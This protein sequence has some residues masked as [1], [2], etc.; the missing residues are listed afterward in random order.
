MRPPIFTNALGT[1]DPSRTPLP[2][3]TMIAEAF[4]STPLEAPTAAHPAVAMKLAIVS[5]TARV[6]M[7]RRVVLGRPRL[8][9]ARD[10]QVVERRKRLDLHL[11]VALEA[12][13]PIADRLV[14]HMVIARPVKMYWHV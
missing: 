11:G 4:N 2:A 1:D 13:L 8:A 5:S 9:G 14:D 3:A 7:P 6:N 12:V 10:E